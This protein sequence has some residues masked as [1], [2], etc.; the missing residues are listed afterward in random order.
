MKRP[1]L[2]QDERDLIVELCLAAQL[3]QL[4]IHSAAQDI[5][6][7]FNADDWDRVRSI[8]AKFDEPT[9]EDLPRALPAP[10]LFD[11]DDD[12]E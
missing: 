1:R 6:D 4:S 12:A 10:T 8:I 9:I 3:H 5:Y 7:A 2:T 11:D